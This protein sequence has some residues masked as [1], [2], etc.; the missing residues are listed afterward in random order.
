MNT[1]KI[2]SAIAKLT[3]TSKG[4][5]SLDEIVKGTTVEQTLVEKDPRSE[6]IDENYITPVSNETIPFH[7]SIFDQ[8]NGQHIKKAAMRTHGSHGPSDLDAN[9]WR[10]IST[11]F[12]QQSI[13]ILKIIAK[14]ARK[15]A[16]EELNPEL[17]EPYNA[18]RLIPLDK[19]PGVRL[20]G[21]EVMRRIIGRT[22]I[23][24]LKNE[25]MS[26]G[27]NYQLCLGQKCGIEYAIHTLR[28]QY[29]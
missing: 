15:L 24:C 29:S 11:H 16:T 8:I 7:P 22:I 14:I 4:V 2:S 6:P 10:R 17:L 18:C 28:D 9:E 13:E 5:L 21:I 3:N 26:L 20:I 1:G 12:G 25:L 19:N 23:K 27:S